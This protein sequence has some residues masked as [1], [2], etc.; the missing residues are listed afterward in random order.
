MSG[1]SVEVAVLG[2]G[3]AGTA[4][5]LGLRKLGYPVALLGSRARKASIEGLAPRAHALLAALGLESAAMCASAPGTRTGEWGGATVAVGAESVVDRSRFD[6]ALQADAVGHGV[7]LHQEPVVAVES[8]QQRWRVRTRTGEVEC[9]V[10]IDARGR[11]SGRTLRR[12]PSLIAVSQRLGLVPAQGAQTLIKPLPQE[13]CWFATDGG[14]TGVL[15]LT[16]SSAGFTSRSELSR[17]VLECL[18]QIPGCER[19]I[20]VGAP[21]ARAATARLGAAS[22]R[23]GYVRCGDACVASDP[24]SGHGIYEALR[25]ARLAVAAAHTYIEHGTWDVV[26]RFLNETAVDRWNSTVGLARSFYQQQAAY[27]PTPFWTQMASAYAALEARSAAVIRPHVEARPVLNGSRIEVRPVVVTAQRP[28][29]VWQID[30]VD[31]AALLQFYRCEPAA[32]ILRAAQH[33]GREPTAV[34]NA[35]GWLAANS[36]RT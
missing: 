14:G 22:E 8:R 36:M 18:P 27:T 3:P 30:S 32:D 17:R 23:P 20:V 4:A 28:R 6:G 9:R 33:F 34:A 1:S 35:L 10:V 25:S 12:G 24:L 19:A 15:Q 21:E 26:A 31:L 29:G 11:R 5:A 7:V 2:G 16:A 13:W